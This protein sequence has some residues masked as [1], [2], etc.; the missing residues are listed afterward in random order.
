MGKWIKRISAV[1]GI[2]I[3]IALTV[4]AVALSYDSPC[5]PTPALVEGGTTM[6]AVTRRCYG[7]PEVL[8]IENVAIPVPADDQMLVKVHAVAINPL[9]WHRVRGTPYAMRLGE[10]FGAP[11]D[12]RLGIDFAGTVQAVGKDVTKFKPG[13]EI[14]GGKNGALAEYVTVREA[15]SI[16]R[17]PQNVS[18]QQA[19]ATYVAALTSLQALRDRAAVKPGQKVLINGA[20]G[21]VGTFAVQ[22][23]KWLGA[24]VTGVC[25]TRNVELVRSLGA[26]HVIDYTQ[27][28]FTESTERYD[29]IM[30]NVANRPIL[31]IR[32]V[33]KPGGK[34][35]VIGGGGPDANP[36]IGAFVAPIKAFVISWF[37]DEDLAFFLSHASVDDVV[38][39]ARLMAEGKVT[40]FVDREYPLAEVQEAMRYLETGRA[41]GKVI[42]TID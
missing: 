8:A 19:A 4:L 42:I 14:F 12:P 11:K 6:K 21:G 35:L 29:V 15:G 13:D 25:S 38:T 5:G 26:D 20:S 27:E 39:M 37:V 32:R 34:Y 31:D 24:E 30:D 7:S 9:D 28:D 3:V 23:A 36:W 41:R 22:L 2:L 10:G 18:F 1:I 17:K 40:P 33:L 16:A